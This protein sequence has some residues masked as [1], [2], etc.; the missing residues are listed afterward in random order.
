M[1]SIEQK[2]DYSLRADV[3]RK[4]ELGSLASE[5]NE[6]LNF[7]ETEDLYK[8][9]QQRLLQEKAEKDALTKVLNK[10]E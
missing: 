4:D 10:K 9:Q 8:T 7:I 5:I 6:L 3:E 1:K 2:Q